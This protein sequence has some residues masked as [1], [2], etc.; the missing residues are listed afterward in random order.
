MAETYLNNR[1]ELFC[2][3]VAGG[4]TQYEAYELAGY[5]PSSA[6]ASTLFNKDIVQK[7]IEEYKADYNRRENEFKL[8]AKQAEEADPQTAEEIRKGAEWSFQRIMDMMGENVRFAQVAGEYRAANE[9][10]KMMGESLK[11]FDSAKS[12]E[13]TSVGGTNLAL[14]GE[15]TQIMSNT[16]RDRDEDDAPSNP[17]RP[18]K[19]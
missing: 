2:K 4:A 15:L 6:N 1:Q 13:T 18:S 7:R 3:F 10:L 11:M 17:L 16:N 19:D 9:T 12:Q 14:I 8:L 5:T